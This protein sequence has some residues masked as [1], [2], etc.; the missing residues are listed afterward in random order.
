M[1]DVTKDPYLSTRQVA[2]LFGVKPYT[3]RQWI[4]D[5]K[6]TAVN[7]NS[8]LKIRKSEVQRLAQDKYG[9]EDDGS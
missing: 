9:S 1:T 2:M 8:R 4:K 5:G 7:I 6:L 3:I